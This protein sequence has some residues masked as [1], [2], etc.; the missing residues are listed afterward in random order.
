MMKYKLNPRVKWWVYRL[1]YAFL[2][3]SA[4]GGLFTFLFDS[5]ASKLAWEMAFM[6]LAGT[7]GSMMEWAN[8][9]DE[10]EG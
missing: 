7:V 9:E 8:P 1:R 3:L 5:A 4:F 10:K 6:L 2:I